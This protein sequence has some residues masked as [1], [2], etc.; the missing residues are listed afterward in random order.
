[1]CDNFEGLCDPHLA[2]FIMGWGGGGKGWGQSWSPWQPMF[3]KGGKGKGKGFKTD[4]ALKVWIG[5][6]APGADWKALQEHMNQ[7][8]KAKWVE[9]FSGKGAG[10]GTAVYQTA[11]EAANAVTML[12]GTG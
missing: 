1:L 6:L 2:F 11:E 4:P 7:A 10:T 9:A 12:N 8:G 5:G 3:M